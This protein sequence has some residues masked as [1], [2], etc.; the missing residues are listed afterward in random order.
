MKRIKKQ[1]KTLTLEDIKQLAVDGKV[2]Q[3][4]VDDAAKS[5]LLYSLRRATYYLPDGRK[6]QTISLV[7]K[8]LS[9]SQLL[10]LWG[11]LSHY[12]KKGKAN[13]EGLAKL[14]QE[15]WGVLKDY[16]Q[17]Q[18]ARAIMFYERRIFGMIGVAESIPEL[19]EWSQ[20]KAEIVEKITEKVDGLVTLSDMI[21]KQ[22]K[23]I[24]VAMA[25]ED[26]SGVRDSWV[27]KEFNAINVMLGTYMKYQIELGV[28]KRQPI[29]ISMGLRQSFDATQKRIEQTVGTKTMVDA[30]DRV[31]T[32]LQ[33]KPGMF[34]L[35]E[36]EE[37]K[38][39]VQN[40]N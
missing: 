24:E 36:M 33:T 5:S 17:W 4:A 28:H 34:E 13:Y 29:E 25:K 14:L 12:H 15:E 35:V 30:T 8:A 6:A 16:S 38:E 22:K 7:G 31:L 39:Q 10:E 11:K 26:E 1:K 23:R 19:K 21:L 2:S 40:T 32:L 18:V 20:K 9:D 27:Y 37:E 3:E